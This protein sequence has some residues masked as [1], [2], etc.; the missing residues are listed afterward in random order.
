M[1]WHLVAS[2]AGI[3]LPWREMR[4]TPLHLDLHRS[5][6]VFG[7]V[8]RASIKPMLL[9]MPERLNAAF[10][11]YGDIPLAPKG[12]IAAMFAKGR[13]IMWLI[14]IALSRPYTF[15]VMAVAIVVMGSMTILST[16][17]DIFPSIG[18]PVL[19]VIWSYTGLPAK[20]IANRISANFERIAPAVVSGIEHTDSSNLNGVGVSKIYFQPGANVPLAMSQLVAGV[21]FYSKF[22]PPGTTP[23]LILSYNASS[24]PVLQLA[25][26]S[27]TM[28]EQAL[29]DTGNIYVRSQLSGVPGLSLPYPYGGKQR[30][31]QVDLY[32]Q[33]L[34][35]FGLSAQDVQN[36]I[37]NQNLIIPVGTQKIGTYEYV[38][39]LN[40]AAVPIDDLNNLPVKEV[41]G[42]TIYVRDVAHVRDGSPP[43]TNMVRL[44][45][46]HAALM[47]VQKTGGASTLQIVH[48]V[49][50]KLPAIQAA[51]PDG[52][53]IDA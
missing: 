26:S 50:A 40:G 52:L 30:Q 31:V 5:W 42:S 45:G 14:K 47:T 8:E 6:Q 20:E 36:A 28:T 17:V 38:V 10:L 18:I 23:P 25:L 22:F 21:T 24:V 34:Q 48:D 29:Y 35:A 43:Q 16:P 49:R 41:N 33:E 53:K 46:E 12:M 1:K 2:A 51:G 19:S 27:K 13:P 4:W 15:I 9:N 7:G 44:N 37:I 11:Y 3:V 32:P 39:D